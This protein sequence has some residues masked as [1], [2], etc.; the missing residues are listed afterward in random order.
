[1]KLANQL[2]DR[3]P[4]ARACVVLASGALLLAVAGTN[5]DAHKAITSKYTYNDD[6]YPILKAKCGSCHVEGGVAPMSLLT[7]DEDGG[8]VAWATSIK[9]MLL[10][11]AM[12]PYFADPTGPAVKGG[13]ELTPR[14]LDTLLTW[15][16]G[17]TPHGDLNKTPAAEKVKNEWRLGKPDATL[18]ME[19]EVTLAPGEMEKRED[20]TLATNFTEDKWARAVDLLPGSPALVRQ[21][22]IGVDG[23]QLITIWQPGDDPASAPQGTAF[24][25]PARAKLRVIIRYKKGWQDEQE[26][27][28]DKSSVGIYFA[29]AGA[30]AIASTN[31]DAPKGEAS[32]VTF[33]GALAAAGKVVAIRPSVDQAYATMDITAVEPS[34]RRV[35]LLKLRAPR[36]EWPRRYW[37]AQPVDIAAGSKIEVKTTPGDKDRGPLGPGVESPLQVGIDTVS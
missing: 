21:A 30:R 10:S 26:S 14:E 32:P 37:L 13:H 20:F 31:I 6:I 15:A 25:I 22:M 5:I 18:E 8:A 7:Y 11:E 29:P 2:R 36:P 23:G 24:K 35:T 28:S 19:K 9:E 34:G 1:M 12:P 17:G 3:R 16:I 27:R 33:S 4:R